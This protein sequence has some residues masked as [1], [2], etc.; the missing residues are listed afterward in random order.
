MVR[1]VLVVVAA[2]LLG[3]CTFLAP[4]GA[5]SSSPIESATTAPS[6]FLS[7]PVA[8]ASPPIASVSAPASPTPSAVPPVESPSATGNP[9]PTVPSSSG[10]LMLGGEVAFASPSGRIWCALNKSAAW[11]HFPA[12]FQGSI[13]SGDKVCPGEELD[14]TGVHITGTGF[15]YFCSGGPTA[16]PTKGTSQVAW[17]D[18]TNFG[19]ITY[20]G[21]TLAP[22]PY[23]QK[24]QIG[25]YICASATNGVTCANRATKH[26]FLI[27]QAGV[28]TF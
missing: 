22:L 11:C 15:G 25:N 19:W 20:D 23:G 26:G 18:Q 24:I 6:G 21:F 14:V 8:S 27:R 4:Q 12:G 2:L 28:A 9:K 17:H 7:P 16:L 10:A 5:G 3:G 13:P 1:S